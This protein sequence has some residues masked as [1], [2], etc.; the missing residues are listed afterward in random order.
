MK[1]YLSIC[2]FTFLPA[3]VYAQLLPDSCMENKEIVLDEVYIYSNKEN[4]AAK[5]R[6]MRD[7]EGTMIFAGK[8]STVSLLE[9]MLLNKAA[10]N[11]RQMFRNVSGIVI[12]EG[13]DGGLQLNIGSRGLNPNR[14]ANFNIRQN[15]YDISADPLGYPESYY[16]PNA[17]DIKEIQVLRGASALQYGSQ[18]GGMINFKL[19]T[20]P[21]DKKIDIR[22]H[23]SAGSYGFLGSYS[24]ISGTIGKF[25]YYLSALLK[26]GDGYRENSDY[27]SYNVLAQLRYQSGE[28]DLWG[29]DWLKYHYLEHQPGGLTDVMFLENPKQSNRSRN[30]FLIDWN[31]ISLSYHRNMPELRAD[32]DVK[33]TGLYA[34]R[35][36]LGYRDKRVGT[37]DPGNTERDL[38]KGT[39]RNWSAEIGF[40]KRFNLGTTS[41]PS[42]WAVGFK[43]FQANNLS[44][45]GAGTT[46]ADADFTLVEPVLS[47]SH[48]RQNK[49]P[50]RSSY[51]LPNLNFALFSEVNL[52]LNEKWS[53]VPGVRMECIQTGIRGKRSYYGIDYATEGYPMTEDILIDNKTNSRRICLAGMALSYK[54]AQSEV[55]ANVT[56]NYRAITFNDMR[57]ISPA[58]EV[59]PDLK[60]ET[61]FSS[62][63]GIR[64]R[65][66]TL[67]TYDVSLFFLYYGNRIGEFFRENPAVKGTYQRYRD[68][69]G[70]GISYGVEGMCNYDFQ[71]LTDLLN[72][73]DFK[74]NIFANWAITGSRY[75]KSKAGYNI[76][77]NKMEFVPLYNLKGGLTA[78]Y[79]RASMALQA[80]FTSFQFTD[81]ANEPMDPND[82]VY[83]ICGAIPGYCVVDL[84]LDYRLN[85]YI[86]LVL[87][88]QNINNSIYMT[89]RASGYPGPGIIPSA[90][91]NFMGT[92]MFHL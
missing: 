15:G 18:F 69:I 68:N 34:D 32:L 53:I 19:A 72:W 51:R 61:G 31:I 47:G 65:G 6:F 78:Q 24:R 79:K 12:H 89:R 57:T 37:P 81:A 20:P 58:L 16:T 9:N 70:N 42:S 90:P 63:V 29:I 55:Y 83:G 38:Q 92:V 11:T 46:G 4:T 77:G 43:Y 22:Q 8:K 73:S 75:L 27:K 74:V 41:V 23:F 1:T 86:N 5:P 85:K 44:H 49:I 50:Y 82:A 25:S 40:L 54:A 88:F 21:A 33:M 60:D 2:L 3:G 35:F 26:R 59:N 48:F 45:Q 84:N 13:S 7:V 64:S 39:F 66:S 87:S 10:N 80:G 71:H 30:W 17:D 62:D 76:E 67:L 52:R 14:S 56:R 91:F 28:N 36:A